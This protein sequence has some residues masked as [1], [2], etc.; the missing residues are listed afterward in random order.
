MHARAAAI[1]QQKIQK[2]PRP[3]NRTSISSVGIGNPEKKQSKLF[4]KPTSRKTAR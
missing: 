4:E 3:E 2:M 1:H